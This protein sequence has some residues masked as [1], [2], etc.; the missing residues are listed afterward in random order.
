MPV[1]LPTTRMR[2]KKFSL[3]DLIQSLMFCERITRQ[4]PYAI[5][6]IQFMTIL[7]IVVIHGQTRSFLVFWVALVA[8]VC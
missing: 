2:K 1:S 7:K 5:W 8:G 3:S 4:A 6:G